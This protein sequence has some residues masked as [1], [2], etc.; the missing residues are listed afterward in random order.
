MPRARK[1]RTLVDDVHAMIRADILAGR[2]LP[3]QPLRMAV[4]RE[5]F[6]VSLSVVREALTRLSEQRLVRSVS[7]L[8]FTVVPLSVA[9]LRDLTSVRI[10][11]ESL[12]IR[13]A[14][15]DGDH[16]WET[17]LT[18]ALRRLEMTL[19]PSRHNA[20]VSDVDGSYREAHA[21]FHTALAA[22]CPSP[23]LREI[24]ARLFEAAELYRHWQV[25]EQRSAGTLA[26]PH[27][28]ICQAVLRRDADTAA[29][30]LAAHIQ[31]A[32]DR[33]LRGAN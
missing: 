7:Q 3:G 22:G 11:I 24:R 29:D 16:T 23:R 25:P 13:R 2:L 30:L 20:Q 18:D 4:L 27:A 15:A 9:D 5:R 33:L 14:V 28:A 10:D 32:A 1:A 31:V 19:P 17:T 8:G 6:D 12:V 26:D 21:E